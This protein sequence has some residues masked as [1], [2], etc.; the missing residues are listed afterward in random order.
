MLIMQ[1]SRFTF[2]CVGSES[3]HSIVVGWQEY[4]TENN[5]IDV[6]ENDVAWWFLHRSPIFFFCLPIAWWLDNWLNFGCLRFISNSP[7][8][9]TN[10][11][12]KLRKPNNFNGQKVLQWKLQ[13][14]RDRR[15]WVNEWMNANRRNFITSRS[16]S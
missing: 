16:K 2:L 9:H 10:S 7:S 1:S 8:F 12:H 4:K 14:A 15:E 5:K 6:S 3:F 11:G 13:E